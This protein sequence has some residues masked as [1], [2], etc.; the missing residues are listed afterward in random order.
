MRLIIHK[1]II[2]RS[3]LLALINIKINIIDSK[4]IKNKIVFSY[5]HDIRF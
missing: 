3:E 5:I 4:K 1:I 2:I